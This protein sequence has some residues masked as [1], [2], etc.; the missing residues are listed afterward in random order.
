[1]VTI[2]LIQKD[3]KKK[4]IHKKIMNIF[5]TGHCGY[6][7]SALMRFLTKCHYVKNIRGYDLINGEDILDKDHLNETMKEFKPDIVIHLAA[8]STVSA[9]NEDIKL[10]IKTNGVGTYN[11]L[12]GMKSIGMQKYYLCQHLF[13][14]WNQQRDSISRV[15]ATNTMFSLWNN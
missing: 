2:Y 5:I 1:M 4:D 3:Q 6:I 10:A 14:L 9:C 7:G 13:C 15:C 8:L 11:V 12:N